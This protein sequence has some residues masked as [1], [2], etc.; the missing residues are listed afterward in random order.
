[1]GLR[2]AGIEGLI[3]RW[4]GGTMGELPIVTARATASALPIG[5]EEEVTCGLACIFH[6]SPEFSRPTR[7][8]G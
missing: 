5:E 3:G 2:G 8:C 7:V 1:M 6:K 4:V